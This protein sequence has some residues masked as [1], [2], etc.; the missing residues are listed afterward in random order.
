MAWDLMTFVAN[1][2]PGTGALHYFN[3]HF[4]GW[5]EICN[6][7]A[8]LKIKDATAF[9][10]DFNNKLKGLSLKA[11]ILGFQYNQIAQ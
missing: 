3:L 5:D 8:I 6:I 4:R 10:H 7:P 1:L 9:L 2:L 11:I